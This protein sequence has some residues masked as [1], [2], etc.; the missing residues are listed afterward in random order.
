MI[1]W[2]S[3]LLPGFFGFGEI[4]QLLVFVSGDGINKLFGVPK[5]TAGDGKNVS[6]DVHILWKKWNITELVCAICFDKM[7][8]NTG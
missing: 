7:S 8:I 4:D 3:K 1:N 5:L 2:N 6:N